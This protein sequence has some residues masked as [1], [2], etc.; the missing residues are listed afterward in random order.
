MT[1]DRAA[2][3]KIESWI[4]GEKLWCSAGFCWLNVSEQG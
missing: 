4:G 3:G 2:A 1:E